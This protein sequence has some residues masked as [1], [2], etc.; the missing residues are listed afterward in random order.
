MI[1][2][3]KNLL[4]KVL[5]KAC[6]T[7]EEM[8]TVLCDCE[9]VLNS[10]PLTYV[11]NEAGDPK[12]LTPAMFLYDNNKNDNPDL[13]LIDSCADLNTRAKRRIEIMQHLR[14]RFRKEYLS[15]L[16]LKGSCNESRAINVGDVV[17]LGDDNSKRVDW[18][19]ARI[20]KLIVGRDGRARV[21]VLRTKDGLY[22]RPIQRIFPLGISA[23]DRETKDEPEALREKICNTP[24]RSKPCENKNCKPLEIRSDVIKTRSGRIIKKPNYY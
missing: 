15:N 8:Y 21:V 14:N 13:D 17:L 16:I 12:P 24:I 2:L 22:K 20:E 3:L 1:G 9:N 6:L 7:Y 23:G 11:S 5:G 10:R 19:L 18:P 4:R